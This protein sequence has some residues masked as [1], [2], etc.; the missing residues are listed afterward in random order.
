MRDAI[1]GGRLRLLDEIGQYES[2]LI[3]HPGCQQTELADRVVRRLEGVVIARSYSLLEYN[4]RREHLAEA[5]QI[6]IAVVRRWTSGF[7]GLANCMG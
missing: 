3:Q 5:E 1:H 7:A 4:I 6:T 2:L